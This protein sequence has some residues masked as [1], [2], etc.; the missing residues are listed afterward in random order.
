M[1]PNSVSARTFRNSTLVLMISAVLASALQ[2][3]VL[4][5]DSNSDNIDDSLTVS[6]AAAGVQNFPDSDAGETNSISEIDFDND[7]YS[8]ANLTNG[9]SISARRLFGANANTMQSIGTG[10]GGLSLGNAIVYGG[11]GAT[12]QFPTAA[13]GSASTGGW[14]L[15]FSTA[16]TYLGIWWSAGNNDNNIQFQNSSGANLLSPTFTTASINSALLNG[17]SCPSQRPTASEITAASWKGYCGNPNKNGNTFI[18]NYVNEPFAF[19]HFRFPTGFTK[20]KLWGTGFEFD[21]LTFSETLPSTGDSEETVGTVAASGLFPSRLVVDPRAT[22][23][24]LPAANLGGSNDAGFCIEQVANSSGGA[25][26][27]SPTI[28]V[29]R[30]VS[31]AGVTETVSTNRWRYTGT[32]A[33]VNSQIPEL[34][35]VG[36]SGARVAPTTSIWIRVRLN[37]ST[38]TTDCSN[39]NPA[40]VQQIIEISPLTI[41]TDDRTSVSVQ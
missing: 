19:I 18:H 1:N 14:T 37:S 40:H 31:T 23:I 7:N 8:S 30:S 20:V 4:A 32:R 29:S 39:T 28:S 16:Q 2:A 15:T 13:S 22:G 35:I 11:A 25:F 6:F 5:T 3:P 24:D 38:T 41:N 26:S 36:A 33:N 27:G 21:N 9:S 12:G 17:N 34:R 10:S